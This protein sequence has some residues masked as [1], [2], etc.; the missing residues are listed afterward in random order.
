MSAV[1]AK[2]MIVASVLGAAMAVSGCVESRL[3][4]SDDYG[5]AL[6]QDVVAQVADPDAHYKGLPAPGADGHRV[7][8]ATDR[9]N[10]D[11]VTPPASTSTSSS[12]S[13]SGGGGG[14]SPPSQ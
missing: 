7:G 6:R 3:H 8:L 10:R 14:G 1:L 5:R 13:G 9:Y 11:A 2:S 12:M 4:L